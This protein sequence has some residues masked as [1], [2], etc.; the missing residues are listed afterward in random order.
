M[1][2]L[3][4]C[5]PHSCMAGWPSVLHPE[6]CCEDVPQAAGVPEAGVQESLRLQPFLGRRRGIGYTSSIV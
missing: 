1:I 2:N 6:N 4:L 5:L 3:S